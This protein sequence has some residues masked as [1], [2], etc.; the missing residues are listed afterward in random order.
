MYCTF[1]IDSAFQLNSNVIESSLFLSVS[2]TTLSIES[3]IFLLYVWLFVCS[4]AEWTMFCLST[5]ANPIISILFDL[6]MNWPVK[7]INKKNHSKLTLFHSNA[8]NSASNRIN[9]YFSLMWKCTYLCVPSQSGCDFDCPHMHHEYFLAV[10]G[11]RI[12]QR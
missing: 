8:C 5:H 4:I 2:H 7:K 12:S 11:N 1:L 3:N 10:N 9:S 6:K